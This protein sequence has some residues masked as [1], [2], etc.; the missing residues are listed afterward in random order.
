MP[1]GVTLGAGPQKNAIN[2]NCRSPN[3]QSNLAVI[4]VSFLNNRQKSL[5]KK[6]ASLALQNAHP[7]SQTKTKDKTGVF[8][9]KTSTNTKVYL[10][11]SP[12]VIQDIVTKEG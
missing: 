1:C 6:N 3:F 8:G 11:K 5:V 7:L 4:C 12:Q 2:Q 9:H 10:L